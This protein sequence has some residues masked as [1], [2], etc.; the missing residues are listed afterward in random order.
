VTIVEFSDLQCPH[1]KDAQPVMT[2]CCEEPNARFVISG[3]YPLP[4]HNWAG[5]GGVLRDCVGRSSNDA[6]WKFVQGTSI[7][8]RISR[9]RMPTR[10]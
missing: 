9:N 3:N 2:S 5:Q 1:C 7:S 8:R 4:M 10:S 6:F